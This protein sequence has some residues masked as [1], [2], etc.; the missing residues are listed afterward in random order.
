MAQ[1]GDI[2][3]FLNTT[4]GGKIARID[5]RIAHVVDEDGFETPVLLSEIVTITPADKVMDKIGR[6]FDSEA[7]TVPTEVKSEYSFRASDDMLVEE[8]AYGDKISMCIA[9]EPSNIKSLA[10]SSF[11]AYIVN[12]SNYYLAVS[13]MKSAD[14]NMWKTVT[15][16]VIEPNTE[17]LADEFKASDIHDMEYVALQFIAYKRGKEFQRKLPV[18]SE[19]KLDLTKFFKV[20]CFQPNQYFD[21]PVL[22]Y[23]IIVD[24]ENVVAK[25][26][27]ER[28]TELQHAFHEKLHERP[29]KRPVVRKQKSSIR[30]N[31]NM[32]EV[33]LH[34]NELLDNTKG[35]SSA[36]ILNYQIDTFRRVMDENIKNHGKKIIFIH[37]KGE[38]VL[39]K[40]LEKELSHKYKGHSVQDASFREYGFGATQVTIR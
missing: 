33:D 31:G 35:M 17:L 22:A 15:A 6:T 23:D 8:T 32:L 9:F 39:R 18:W 38:G 30:E 19:R 11:S 2:V 7:N 40:A 13:Y 1:Q 28:H 36:D 27:A 20:H 4:G 14:G 21:T 24:D 3:R 25:Q 29:V 37:G 26:L 10:S 5:G 16:T 34:I 12:D